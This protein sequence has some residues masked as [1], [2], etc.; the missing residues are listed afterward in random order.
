MFYKCI[1]NNF[2]FCYPQA[3]KLWPVLQI[4]IFNPT[5]ADLY[6]TVFYSNA[7]LATLI[8]LIGEIRFLSWLLLTVGF[9]S[10]DFIS[11]CIIPITATTSSQFLCFTVLPHLQK[12]LTISLL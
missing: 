11:S 3:L 7:T 12:L 6:S 8:S 4:P 9:A 10:R 1:G 2:T 5:N